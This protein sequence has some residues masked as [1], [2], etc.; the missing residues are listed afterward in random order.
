MGNKEN[1]RNRRKA[2]KLLG[3]GHEYI[4]FVSVNGGIRQLGNVGLTN[5]FLVDTMA[6]RAKVLKRRL[7]SLERDTGK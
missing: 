3:E 2:I 6:R 1:E 7:I 5:E 4:L